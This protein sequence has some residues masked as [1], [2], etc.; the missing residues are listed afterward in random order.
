MP[1]AGPGLPCS[2]GMGSRHPLGWRRFEGLL[3]PEGTR[4]GQ[5]RGRPLGVLVGALGR[6]DPS[7]PACLLLGQAGRKRAGPGATRPSGKGSSGGFTLAL[8]SC[9][10]RWQSCGQCEHPQGGLQLLGRQKEVGHHN[11]LWEE[12]A[13]PCGHLWASCFLL[14]PGVRGVHRWPLG[15]FPSV[16]GD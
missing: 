8:I 14:L 1:R 13:L 16:L 12:V 15:G 3:R 11:G 9:A 2:L 7:D 5:G 6:K 10:C 4:S